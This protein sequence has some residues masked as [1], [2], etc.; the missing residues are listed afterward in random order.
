MLRAMAESFQAVGRGGT[1][2]A[3]GVARR[4][5]SRQHSLWPLAAL[6]ACA[7]ACAS[8][9]GRVEWDAAGTDPPSS[10]SPHSSAGGADAEHDAPEAPPA[11]GTA[12]TAGAVSDAGGAANGGD[13]AGGAGDE[14][15]MAG[16][17]GVSNDPASPVSISE[18]LSLNP[19]LSGNGHYL[20]FKSWD[21]LVPGLDTSGTL[22]VYRL[23][24]QSDSVEVVSRDQADAPAPGVLP[25]DSLGVSFD[26]RYVVFSSYRMSADSTGGT[27]TSEQL[28]DVY[29]RDITL[30][31]TQL[32][33]LGVDGSK[34]EGYSLGPTLSDD[35]RFLAFISRATPTTGNDHVFVRDLK[36]GS[37]VA[38]DVPLAGGEAN[39][40]AS[41]AY[42]SGNGRYV[43]FSSY[44]SNLPAQPTVAAEDVFVSDL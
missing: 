31:T 39:N 29:L 17:G 4:S 42:I 10:H 20:I 27:G 18:P 37:T 33:S 12:G 8:G 36:L 22:Q 2:G 15:G 11:L 13:A 6:A 23:D 43:A 34:G 7:V 9:C 24:L 44:A 32:V 26:G 1:R 28:I 19:V 30:G 16:A 35:G 21:S 25:G 41:S 3:R 40:S 38:V 5:G 14:G